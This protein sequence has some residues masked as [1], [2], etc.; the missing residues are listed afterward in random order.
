MK[1]SNFAVLAISLAVASCSN[2]DSEDGQFENLM[3]DRRLVQVITTF[4]SG[5][6][7]ELTYSYDASGFPATRTETTN[8]EVSDLITIAVGEEGLV[9]TLTSD[10]GVDGVVDSIVTYGYENGRLITF[11]IDNDA[12]QIADAQRTNSFDSQGRFSGYTR[13]ALSSDGQQQEQTADVVVSYPADSMVVSEQDFDPLGTPDIRIEYMV[14]PKGQFTSSVE[15]YFQNEGL[16][17]TTEW[18]YEDGLCDKRWLGSL[19]TERC[20]SSQE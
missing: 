13:Y 10:S 5:Q 3:G 20:V 6:V 12:D 1:V 11:N 14:L 16:T 2:D 17:S 4:S 7:S 9:D 18:V 8:G 19:Y 15:T